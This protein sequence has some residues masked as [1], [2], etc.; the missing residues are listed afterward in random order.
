VT[1]G[2]APLDIPRHF[3]QIVRVGERIVAID[4]M[5]GGLS[6]PLEGIESRLEAAGE[7]VFLRPCPK[8]EN[9]LSERPLGTN[10]YEE[11][12]ARKDGA[13]LPVQYYVLKGV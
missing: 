4:A 12:D 2:L 7:R 9:I 13:Q 3:Y 11:L 10:A 6:D 1:D 8:F 5:M